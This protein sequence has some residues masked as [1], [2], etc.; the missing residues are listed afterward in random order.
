MNI[1]E[2][3]YVRETRFAC[4]FKLSKWSMKKKSNYVINNRPIKARQTRLG[5]GEIACHM[6]VGT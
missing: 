2:C 5:V 3:E 1:N 6:T 4:V